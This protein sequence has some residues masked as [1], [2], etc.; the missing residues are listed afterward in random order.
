MA[1]PNSSSSSDDEPFFSDPYY[2]KNDDDEEF[3][4][5]VD[6]ESQGNSAVYKPSNVD[7]EG[8]GNL[9]VYDNIEGL[10][11]DDK[12]TDEVVSVDSSSDDV[13]RTKRKKYPFFNEDTDFDNPEFSVG[14]EFKTHK[15]FRDAVKEYAIKW[16]KEIKFTLSDKKKGSDLVLLEGARFVVG[17]ARFA[18]E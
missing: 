17:R 14:M 15:L 6:E 13:G 9:A 8:Q 18:V 16:G 4:S 5:N 10:D 3:D 7:E 1:N 11:V 2:E 12:D